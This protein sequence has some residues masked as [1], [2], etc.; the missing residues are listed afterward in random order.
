MN[1]F[2]PQYAIP[3]AVALSLSAGHHARAESLADVVA[4]AYETNPGLQAQRAALKGLDES[5]VQARSGYGLSA[6]AQAGEQD[7][8]LH[9]SGPSGGTATAQ[10][11][12]ESLSI[13]QPIWTGGR[14]SARMSQAEAQIRSGREQV[15]RYE[16]DLLVRVVTAYLN[17][18]RDLQLLQINRDT[19][20]VLERELADS[21][22]KADVREVTLTDVAQSKARLAQART[23]L[24]AAEQSL[25]TSRAQFLGVVGQNPGDLDA[26]PDIAGLPDNPNA[27]FEAAERNNPQLLSAQ[28]TEQGSRAAIAAAKAQALPSVTARADFQHAPYQPFLATP[29]QT[30]AVGSVTISIPLLAA[31]QIGSGIRQASQENNRDRLTVDDVRLQVVQ[32]ISTSWE[33]LAALRKQLATLEDEVK[34]DEFA[35]YGVRQEEKFAL[36]STI[37]ILNAEL[38]LTTAQQNLVRA[39]TNEYVSRVQ[40]LASIGTLTPQLLSTNVKLYDPAKNF[41]EVKDKGSIPPLELPARALD[42][43]VSFP[44]PGPRPAAIAVNRPDDTGGGEPLPSTPGPQ[45]PVTSIL[46]DLT[47]VGPPPPK[48]GDDPV[49]RSLRV[50][51]GRLHGDAGAQ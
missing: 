38:E 15:R 32:G 30:T 2:R 20:A 18:K 7:Y 26:P 10:T 6:S 35:F 21:Q 27:A 51:A 41:N 46:S 24:A 14:V 28:Y 29:Y 49:T 19:V 45:A 42:R 40:L 22:S 8:R 17:V 33:Q 9:L 11:D 1:L 36:R 5:Y 4:Y 25:G 23:S 16:L 50:P 47:D 44:V 31:G 3:A 43:L 13:V 48:S 34:A 37:E 12:S 39:R